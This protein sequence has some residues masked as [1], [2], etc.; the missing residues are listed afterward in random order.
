MD[1]LK[2]KST[3]TDL[4]EMVSEFLEENFV[5]VFN[6]NAPSAMAEVSV[7]HTIEQMSGIIEI[8]DQVK[9]GGNLFQVTALGEEANKTFSELGHCTFKFT[10]NDQ[11]QLPGE[12]ELKGNGTPKIDVGDVIEIS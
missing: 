1:E 8:G 7:L 9:I 2:Y 6:N 3:V 10:G 4:G 12:I 5:I 11:V